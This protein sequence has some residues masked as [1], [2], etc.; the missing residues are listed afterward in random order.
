MSSSAQTI[1]EMCRLLVFMILLMAAWGKTSHFDTFRQ[2]LVEGFKLPV[3]L[4]LPS[5]ILLIAVEWLLAALLI[6]P[7]SLNLI[8]MQATLALFVLF[9]VVIATVLL[10]DKLVNC[11]CFGQSN[12]PISRYDLIRNLLTIAACSMMLQLTPSTLALDSVAHGLLF[13]N[14]FIVFVLLSKLEEIA[15]LLS[16]HGPDNHQE[17]DE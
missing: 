2:N 13:A 16:F 8:A 17:T 14:A 4:S 7:S 1:S 15:V 12:R 9:T 10:Q 6:I 5:A 3:V 11:N